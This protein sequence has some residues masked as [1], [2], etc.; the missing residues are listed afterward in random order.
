MIGPLEG[1][2]VVNNEPP[3]SDVAWGIS[4]T[5]PSHAAYATLGTSIPID[6]KQPT[7][8]VALHCEHHTWIRDAV[9]E[10]PTGSN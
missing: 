3:N 9:R 1:S 5:A 2:D 7:G 6:T 10:H 4:V 8:F